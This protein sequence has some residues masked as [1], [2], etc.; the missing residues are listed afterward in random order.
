MYLYLISIEP[1]HFHNLSNVSL[2]RKTVS[3]SS[4]NRFIKNVNYNLINL[5]H[6]YFLV[7]LMF[8]A[9]VHFPSSIAQYVE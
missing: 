1:H 4:V 5:Y 3:R 8:L 7:H 6:Y 9:A 2:L